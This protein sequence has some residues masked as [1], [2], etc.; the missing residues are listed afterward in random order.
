MS[1]LNLGYMTSG[2]SEALFV[3]NS[4]PSK[5]MTPLYTEVFENISCSKKGLGIESLTSMSK[6]TVHASRV[7]LAAEAL[8]YQGLIYFSNGVYLLCREKSEL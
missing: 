8:E 7:R 2:Q 4:K 6:I 5:V 1:S 3:S